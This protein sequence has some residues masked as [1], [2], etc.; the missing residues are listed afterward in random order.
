MDEKIMYHRLNDILATVDKEEYPETVRYIECNISEDEAE[1]VFDDA[2][3]IACNLHESDETKILPKCVAELLVDVYSEEI[4][5]ENPVA[6]TNL[7][8]LY[9]T[10]R[11]GEQNYEKAVVYYTM[12]DK[13][14]EIQATENLG[15]CYYY[16]RTGEKDYKKA[17]HYFV[18]G[19]LINRINS[20]Y[21][22]GDMYKNGYYV[23]KDEKEAFCIYSRCY[24]LMK[25]AYTESFGAD[26]CM[27]LGDAYYYG[28]GTEKDIH[29]ALKYYQKSERYF[30]SKIESGD[31]FAKKGLE[32][33]IRKQ[34]EIRKELLGELPDFDWTKK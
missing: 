11:G 22:I 18:K 6:M 17:Y 26:I 4:A 8:A 28:I 29:I 9:Y 3:E 25:S 12:A 21:K 19:A 2:F 34:D 23:E 33:V 13:Y 5:N 27:R 10:G 32:N 15:Y 1:E 16:G 31:Y 7:G 30:Y 14:G 20:L 24:E